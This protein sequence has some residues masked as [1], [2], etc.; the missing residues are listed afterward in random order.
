MPWRVNTSQLQVS[1]LGLSPAWLCHYRL[2]VSD[3]VF[4]SLR[5][6]ICDVDMVV[7]AFHW[8]VVRTKEPSIS[9]IVINIPVS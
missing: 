8:V 9:A 1:F 7:S 2:G 4:L 3:L 5:S 6:L